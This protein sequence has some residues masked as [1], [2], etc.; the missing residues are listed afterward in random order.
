MSTVQE[1]E[2][3]IQALPLADRLRV[4]MD[5]PQLIGREIEDVDWQWLALERFFQDD[6]PGDE[7]YGRLRCPR[8]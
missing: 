2:K 6:S 5:I 8:A 1:I 4:Y 3:Q 7:A